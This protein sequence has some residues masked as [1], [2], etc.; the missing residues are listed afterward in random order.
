MHSGI[1]Q[2]INRF[3]NDSTQQ[4]R[5]L[6][7]LAD[8]VS[9]LGVKSK[10]YSSVLES[11]SFIYQTALQAFENKRSRNPEHDAEQAVRTIGEYA[12]NRYSVGGGRAFMALHEVVSKGPR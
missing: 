12:M 4:Q 9:L 10:P 6:S 2:N 8:S 11:A 7:E 5:A 3:V 1:R